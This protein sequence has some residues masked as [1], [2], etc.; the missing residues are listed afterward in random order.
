MNAIRTYLVAMAAELRNLR[1]DTRGVTAVEFGLIAPVLMIMLLGVIEGTRAIAL[2]QR[3]SLATNMV[4]DLVAREQVL[5]SADV[6]KIYEVVDEVMQPYGTDNL[7][8]LLIPVMS[9][10]NNAN[11]TLVYPSKDNRPSLPPGSEP[12]KCQPYTLA[13]DLI[14]ANESVI[15]VETRYAYAPLFLNW[16]KNPF[17]ANDEAEPW[18]KKAY[19]KPRK[20]LCVAFDGA[21]CTSSCFS[22]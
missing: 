19:A 4:A 20:S 7:R 12:P 21:N 22:S 15:V 16:K 14:K 8:I 17:K 5:T 10:P 2:D 1:R 3:L 18:Q 13:K 9:A 6:T 11:Q